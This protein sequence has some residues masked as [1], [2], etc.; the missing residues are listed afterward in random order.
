MRTPDEPLAAFVAILTLPPT[1]TLWFRRSATR[2][3]EPAR[4]ST[5]IICRL[6]IHIILLG[7]LAAWWAAWDFET[8]S[9]AL[10][11]WFFP[12]ARTDSALWNLLWFLLPPI[13]MIATVKLICYAHDRTVFARR[14]T[15]TN[16]LRLACWSTASPFVALLFVA[17]GFDAI[18]D[19]RSIAILWLVAAAVTGI[20]GTALLRSA[21]G[22]KTRRIKS[23][24]LYKRSLVLAKTMG[25]HVDRV[26][27]VP[28]GRGQLTN[29]YGFSQS[30]A[31]TDNYGKFLNGPQLDFVIGHELAH[32]KAKHGRK[33]LLLMC[34][35]YGSLAFACI[36]LPS[37][38]SQFRPLC[39]L[40]VVFAPLMTF[41]YFSRR[42]EYV[43]DS[44]SIKFTR[45]PEVAIRALANLLRLTQ[46]PADYDRLSQLFMTHP[47]F[48]RRAR[49]IGE[50]SQMPAE[51]I[52]EAILDA[53]SR[54][55]TPI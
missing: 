35:V 48:M 3:S 6:R 30:V 42:W 2:A 51:L 38:L 27:I 28:A 25:T 19:R 32:V 55:A 16:L 18:Y 49:A 39:D 5:W 11:D 45:N 47:T 37:R 17:G 12:F 52:S 15:L 40:F 34:A 7:A 22:M 50:T 31:L 4:K 24:E 13:A 41:R 33:K 10:L 21:E 14:W 26:Y 44:T 29:A 23:G 9:P 20:V 54:I 46:A 43:A 36:L 53:R 8:R 1:L